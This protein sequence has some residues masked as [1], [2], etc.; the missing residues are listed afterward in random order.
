M[1]KVTKEK[2]MF[3]TGDDQKLDK[4]KNVISDENAMTFLTPEGKVTSDID[5]KR[6]L[7]DIPFDHHYTDLSH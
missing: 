5:M 7:Y 1:D 6:Y 2:V 3:V 4:V